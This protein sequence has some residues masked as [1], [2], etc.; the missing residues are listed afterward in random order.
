M[1]LT[2]WKEAKKRNNMTIA[3]IAEKAGLPKV[4]CKIFLQDMSPRPV[5]TQYRQ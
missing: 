5:L 3:D 1:D 4:R 2:I